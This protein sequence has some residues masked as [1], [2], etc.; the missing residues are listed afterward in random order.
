LDV[1]VQSVKLV[2]LGRLRGAEPLIHRLA[3]RLR[4]SLSFLHRDSPT[5]SSPAWKGEALTGLVE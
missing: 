2:L 4:H 5:P 3:F 1:D